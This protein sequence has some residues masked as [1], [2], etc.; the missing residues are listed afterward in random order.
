MSEALL[1][2]HDTGVYSAS[3]EQHGAD[4]AFTLQAILF[5]AAQPQRGTQHLHQGPMRF[6]QQLVLLAVDGKRECRSVHRRIS[7]MRATQRA[8]ARA[9][10]VVTS[11]RRYSADA[12]TSVMGV[13]FWAASLP[14]SR[15]RSVSGARASRCC[16]AGRQRSVLAPTA[17][18]AMR[19]S[20]Q[21]P[22][23]TSSV[24][25]AAAHTMEISIARRRPA[26]RKLVA[27]AAGILA[28]R[29]KVSNS[30]S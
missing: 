18:R 7:S 5:R 24:S 1:R 14:A 2:E 13:Q 28:N 26:F 21:T 6:N 19:A 30:A 3:V 20:R 9:T 17:P 12:R 22:L 8:R 16:S 4:A 10:N 29:I 15:R 27:V 11:R 23:T 25:R